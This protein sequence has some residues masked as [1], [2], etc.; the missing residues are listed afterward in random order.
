MNL[1]AKFT[2][3]LGLLLA[4]TFNLSAQISFRSDSLNTIVIESDDITAYNTVSNISP[5]ANTI[6]WTKNIIEAP[7][8][9]TFTI[10][11]NNSC[12][13]PVVNSAEVE[14][15][16]SSSSLLDLHLYPNGVYE[17]Y[18][19]MEVF[20]EF[21]LDSTVNNTAVYVFNSENPSS[22]E[23][24]DPISF[25]VYPNPSTGLFH[26]NVQDMSN[27]PVTLSVFDALGRV[28]TS[29][30]TTISNDDATIRL[31]LSSFTK[32]VYLLQLQSSQGQITEKIMVN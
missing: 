26:I 16:P 4:S 9:W 29:Y 10:C 1:A 14:L 25:N 24:Q 8:A 22:S 23:F 3:I 15:G 11:D 13:L 18:G 30:Q 2:C 5:Q 32:G 6:R 31:D 21:A 19:V 7:D 28:V 27:E 12:Y 20:V 17:G